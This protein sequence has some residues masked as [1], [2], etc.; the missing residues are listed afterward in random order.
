MKRFY[1]GVGSRE[2]P[3][4]VLQTMRE[5][6]HDLARC[7]WVLRSGGADGADSAFE[8]GCLEAQG[9]S[10]IYLPWRGF[11][12]N[13][14]PLFGVDE[15]ALTLAATVHPAWDRLQ[16]GPRKLHARNCY[17][18][19]GSALDVPSELT[20]CWT[21][22]GCE[23]GARRSR[24]TGGTATAIVLSERSGVPVYNLRNA[25]SVTRLIAHLAR[26]GVVH[27]LT[28]PA[29]DPGPAQASLF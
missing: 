11:N 6:A 3:P 9:D 16:Q 17:Q 14:S 21:P 2:T 10:H 20:V 5:L 24:E 22:D 7:G 12:R 15:A 18:V 26:L 13:A 28:A 19:L 8:Q 27:R 25:T 29:A 1:T 4:E 23:Q